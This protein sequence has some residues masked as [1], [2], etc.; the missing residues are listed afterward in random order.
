VLSIR[1]GLTL[2]FFSPAG[3]IYMKMRFDQ[4]KI[5]AMTLVDT[6][7]SRSGGHRRENCCI[8]NE[9]ER[10]MAR[11]S[12]EQSTMFRATRWDL[13]CAGSL[14]SAPVSARKAATI[15]EKIKIQMKFYANLI[16]FL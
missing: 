9:T 4:I 10:L 5:N 14:L 12:C 8:V 7:Q 11:V 1:V 13:S 16:G 15:S 2:R 3:P 6:Q